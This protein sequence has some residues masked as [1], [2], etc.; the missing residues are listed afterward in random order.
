M[1]IDPRTGRVFVGNQGRR[2]RYHPH[3]G[4][5]PDPAQP[6]RVVDVY[7][8]VSCPFAHFSLRRF[9]DRRRQAGTQH[10]RLRVYAWPLE[11]ANG[12]PLDAG[13]VVD[14]I[15]DLRAQVAGD[16]FGG[17]DP[18]AFPSSTI[19]ILGTA[20]L[21]YQHGADIGETFNLAIREALFEQGRPIGDP[22]VLAEIA[23]R[24]GLE[25]PDAAAARA[26]VDADFAEGERRGVTG[27]PYF[28]VDGIPFFCPTLDIERQGEH[29]RIDIDDAEF[30]RFIDRALQ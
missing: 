27:S 21:A 24:F 25:V 3:P 17:F 28:I 13:K 18:A 7:A 23:A 20:T 22:D 10:V 2:R 29:L 16:L 5:M 14:E 30:D 1:T 12:E 9:S 11:L 4:T 15:A 19:A 26:V 8:D 6:E